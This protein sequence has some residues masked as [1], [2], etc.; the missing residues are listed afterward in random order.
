MQLRAEGGGLPGTPARCPYSWY[1]RILYISA[2]PS[3]S[4]GKR[5]PSQ[6]REQHN[7]FISTHR[8]AKHPIAEAAIAD[9]DL[10]PRA[11][12]PEDRGRVEQSSRAHRSLQQGRCHPHPPE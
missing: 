3:S 6:Y 5:G 2:A 8:I 10:D 9:W 11:S 4:P 1:R 7:T 12:C